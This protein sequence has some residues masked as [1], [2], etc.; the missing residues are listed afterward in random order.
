M[1]SCAAD[2]LLP[3]LPTAILRTN[4]LAPVN[5]YLVDADQFTAPPETHALQRRGDVDLRQPV[6]PQNHPLRECGDQWLC[7]PGNPGAAADQLA[8]KLHELERMARHS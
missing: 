8:A 5:A 4:P 6:E 7:V 2:Q 1:P 3:R